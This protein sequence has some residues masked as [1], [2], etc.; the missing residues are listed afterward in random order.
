MAPTVVDNKPNYNILLL[1]LIA[2]KF[3]L[4]LI[5]HNSGYDLHRDE[6]LHLDIANHPAWGYQSVPPLISWV[7]MVIKLLGNGVFWVRFFPAL[8]GA[9]TLVVVWKT[10]SELKGNLLAHCLAGA[11][12][13]FSALVRINFL[14][15]P[16]SFDVLGWTVIYYCIIKWINRRESKW[17]YFA[18][19]AFGLSFLN[20]YNIAFLAVGLFPAILLTRERRLFLHKHFYGAAAVALF[21]MSPNIWWQYQNGFPVVHHMK[22]LERTQLV[23]VSRAG[24]FKEQLIYFMGAL[25]LLV[26]GVV[27][28]FTAKRFLKYRLFGYS[29]VFTLAAFVY[30]KAK[31]YYAIGLY[32]VFIAFGAVYIG[33]C[34]VK[35]YKGFTILLFALPVAFYAL[36]FPIAFRVPDPGF[37]IRN[38]DRYSNSGLLR[39]EDGKEHALPQDFSDMLGWK[40]LA[41]KTDSIM[42]TIPRHEQTL[43]LCDNYGQAGAVNYYTGLKGLRAVSFNADYINW[44]DLREPVVNVLRVKEA[45]GSEKELEETGPYFEK[46]LKAA[47][48]ET[49]NAREFGTSVFLFL[50][51]RIDV[52][53]VLRNEIQASKMQKQ[54][55]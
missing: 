54:K 3:L 26:G 10:V 17:L 14:F 53:A 50:K 49:P 55:D 22:E 32:P 39:W 6:Y 1:L 47:V 19:I 29:F 27:A 13:L 46:G 48:V 12:V 35:R 37:F 51:A 5:M 36:L 44:F 41:R 23:N 40:E 52:N 15:Q 9:A 25:P 24:F 2:L 16:N 33:R 30:F 42:L 28:L 31:G 20:K 7:A 38:H 18:A 43:I 45:R 11:G 4:Q 8:F 34:L 21:I